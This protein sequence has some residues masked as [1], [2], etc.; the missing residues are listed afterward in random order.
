M[1]KI[2]KK[3]DNV[4][5]FLR[6]NGKLWVLL[7][8][9]LAG[10]VLM[11]LGSA[12]EGRETLQRADT[13]T[14]KLTELSSYEQ[15]LESELAHL[16]ASVAGVGQVEVMVH[17]SAGARVQYT[18]DEK[19]APVTVGGGSS[20]QALYATLQSPEI[21]GVGIVCRGGSS[22]AVQQRLTELVSTTLGIPSSRVFVT[23]K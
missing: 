11:L 13:A 2:M 19:G 23:G 6:K 21:A 7:G 18:S 9:A 4:W 20:E 5:A 10:I 8:G 15:A 17:L 22:A 12:L 16:C 14:D 3:P 1:E